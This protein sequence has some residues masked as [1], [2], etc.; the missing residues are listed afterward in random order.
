MGR[1]VGILPDL[2]LDREVSEMIRP[3]ESLRVEESG[4]FL[5]YRAWP[6]F[7][8]PDEGKKVLPQRNFAQTLGGL[9]SMRL[10]SS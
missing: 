10:R 4:E 9:S 2:V 1:E 7:D 6:M 8:E 3:V 5:E